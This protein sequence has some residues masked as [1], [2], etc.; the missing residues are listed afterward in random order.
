MMP[1]SKLL[2]VAL[3]VQIVTFYCFLPLAAA[4]GEMLLRRRA[5]GREE[6]LHR[7]SRHLQHNMLDG[8]MDNDRDV[9]VDSRVLTAGKLAASSVSPRAQSESLPPL[10]ENVPPQSSEFPPQ[11]S[12]ELAPQ[13]SEFPPAQPSECPPLDNQTLLTGCKTVVSHVAAPPFE[14]RYVVPGAEY[15]MRIIRNIVLSA[16]G[17]H[18]YYILER[19][20]E[21]TDGRIVRTA[22]SCMSADL[23]RVKQGVAELAATRVIS[24][25]WQAAR[26]N[27]SAPRTAVAFER[28]RATPYMTELTGLELSKRST[29]L[30]LTA[31]SASPSDPSW[32]VAV[33][34]INGTRTSIEIDAQLATG[35]AFNPAKTELYIS[36]IYDPPEI[37]AV[38]VDDPDVPSGYVA[39]RKVMAF[40][41]YLSSAN[42]SSPVVGPYGFDGDGGCL[43]FVDQDFN[44]LWGFETATRTVKLIAAG[45]DDSAALSSTSGSLPPLLI[46]MEGTMVELAATSDGLTIF[47][48]TF[49]GE[50]F[51]ISLASPCEAAMAAN[52]LIQVPQS[53]LLGLA[54]SKAGDY[55]LVGTNYG[56][57]LEL[58]TNLS[59]SISNPPPASPSGSSVSPTS[60]PS[61]ASQPQ[62]S[63]PLRG[64]GV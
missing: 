64:T 45:S 39:L 52:K 13:P 55:L 50:L 48:I 9:H 46:E 15:C 23:T 30:L 62:P 27:G 20:C 38:A 14:G 49:A 40:D 42:G 7:L 32:I 61:A 29:H 35:L 5:R 37:F 22:M 47:V 26:P 41:S 4:Q 57:V 44:R 54:I 18:F 19:R 36:D 21:D 58:S 59:S 56:Q 17:L 2:A 43:Y 53:S 6:E 11:R 12:E 8:V 33:N 28:D 3:A 1:S 24:H 60:G 25:W 63:S 16:D 31:Y 34:I 10:S 51:S